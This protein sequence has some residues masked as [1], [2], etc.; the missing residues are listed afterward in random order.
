MDSVADGAYTGRLK[1]RKASPPQPIGETATLYAHTLFV[2]EIES[3]V[4]HLS[5]NEWESRAVIDH[6]PALRSKCTHCEQNKP[7]A[8]CRFRTFRAVAS[9][10]TEEFLYNE[11]EPMKAAV[12]RRSFRISPG[13]DL[14]Q[15]A[16]IQRVSFAH[17]T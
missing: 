5:C 16:D 8:E 7:D 13:A 15:E 3:T 10:V 6:L 17:L 9:S 1:R 4:Q 14:Y 11:G 12:Y 2:S